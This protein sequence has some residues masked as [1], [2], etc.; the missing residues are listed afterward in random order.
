MDKFHCRSF[1]AFLFQ[2]CCCTFFSAVKRI[3]SQLDGGGKNCFERIKYLD[4]AAD[5]NNFVIL[6]QIFLQPIKPNISSG[7]I[8]DV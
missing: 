1:L 6:C 7:E 4:I 8:H 2:G 3:L 5:E